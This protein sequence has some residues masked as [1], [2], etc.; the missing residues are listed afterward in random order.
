MFKKTYLSFFFILSVLLSFGQI[1]DPSDKVNWDITY[2]QVNCEVTIIAKITMA[3]HWHIS[4]AYLPL[5]CFSIPTSITIEDHSGYDVDDSTF[6]P[7][8]IHI[9]DSLIGE[10]L[11][12]HS[13]TIELRKKN[14]T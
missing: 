13:G 14:N 10:D 2:E 7:E 12:W 6:E 4:A 8:P 5:D 3:N 1:E 11:Y 9:Y